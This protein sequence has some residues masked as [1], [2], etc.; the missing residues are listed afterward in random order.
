MKYIIICYNIWGEIS[1]TY[2]V[3]TLEEAKALRE[4]LL[5]DNEDIAI[6]ESTKIKL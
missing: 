2:I 1:S 5:I 4:S 6:W 3:H